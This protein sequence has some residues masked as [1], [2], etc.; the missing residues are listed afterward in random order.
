MLDAGYLRR[1]ALIDPGKQWRPSRRA[2][3]CRRLHGNSR[4]AIP[5]ERPS[6]SHFSIVDKFGDAVAMTMSVQG[7]FGSQLMV[8]GFILNNQLTDFDYV[9][10]V[11]GGP[12]ANR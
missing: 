7:A 3:R 9:P 11:D 6:T 4:P 12:V 5:S 2:S 1:A 8:G 10:T